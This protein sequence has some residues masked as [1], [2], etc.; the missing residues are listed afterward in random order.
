M[1]NRL[2]FVTTNT[3]TG[4]LGGVSGADSF[5]MNDPGH[6]DAAQ[7]LG[8]R[9]S[10]KAFITTTSGAIRQWDSKTLNGRIDWV[11]EANMNYFRINGSTLIA[12][13]GADQRFGSMSNSVDGTANES[14]LGFFPGGSWDAYIYG[15]GAPCPM[16]SGDCSGF[17]SASNALSMRTLIQNTTTMSGLYSSGA[18]RTCDVPRR[19]WCI[20]Q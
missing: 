17:S 15:C 3:S 8:S 4:N 16:N 12:T 1:P 18:V 2:T 20:Q 10:F 5:C 9:R 13:T 19:L 14:W 6:P 7:A 11:M